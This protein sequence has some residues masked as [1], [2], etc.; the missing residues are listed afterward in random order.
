MIKS[1]TY[2]D[3]A[4]LNLVPIGDGLFEDRT[5]FTSGEDRTPQTVTIAVDPRCHDYYLADLREV[6]NC[7]PRI[8]TVVTWT[9]IATE[10]DDQEVVSILQGGHYFSQNYHTIETDYWFAHVCFEECEDGDGS[11][12]TLARIYVEGHR[13]NKVSSI[14]ARLRKGTFELTREYKRDSDA[15][16]RRR[17]KQKE[18]WVQNRKLEEERKATPRPAIKKPRRKK[19][20]RRVRK[21]DSWIVRTETISVSEFQHTVR[22]GVYQ[23]DGLVAEIQVRP[24]VKYGH[25][26]L[27]KLK[28][29]SEPTIVRFLRELKADAIRPTRPLPSDVRRR[30][31]VG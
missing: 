1:C 16:L 14:F 2:V 19:L 6:K 25:R 30:A 20:A 9:R 24:S 7:T 18:E 26:V 23:Y 22:D 5:T 13:R 10:I 17:V 28:A 21:K 4:Q 29:R 8:N 31:S 3:I 15:K 11:F 12:Y 27:V